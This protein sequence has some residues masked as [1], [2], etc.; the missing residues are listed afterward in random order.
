MDKDTRFLARRSERLSV[1]IRVRPVPKKGGGQE[2][3]ALGHSRGD[4]TTKIH[5]IVDLL[6]THCRRVGQSRR[7]IGPAGAPADY[8]P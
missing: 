4:F 7:G 2:T 5:I 8:Q 3:Q 1:P 6:S